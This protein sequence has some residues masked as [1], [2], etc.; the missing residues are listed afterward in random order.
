MLPLA[1]NLPDPSSAA[2]IGWLVLTLAGLAVA[3]NAIANFWR[4]NIREQ[5]TPSATYATKA[6]HSEL[7][8]QLDVELGRERASRKRMHEE[9]AELQ[10][11]MKSMRGELNTQSKQVESMHDKLE[12]INKRIDLVPV[13]LLEM[14]KTTK[15]L[16]R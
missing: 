9:I 16:H 2:S 6:E 8:A 12:E 4:Q 15:E 5:P 11:D 3:V 13:R 7:R 14:L 1:A 10:G